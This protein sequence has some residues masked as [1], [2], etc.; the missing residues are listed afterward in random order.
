MQTIQRFDLLD[1]SQPA[2]EAFAKRFAAN[3]DGRLFAFVFKDKGQAD[4]AAKYL[5]GHDIPSERSYSFSLEAA[6]YDRVP[7]FFLGIESQQALDAAG[8]LNTEEFVER[9][10]VSDYASSQVLVSKQARAYLEVAAPT[11]GWSAVPGSSMSVMT[12]Q[13]KLAPPI[14]LP[15]AYDWIENTDHP[16]SWTIRGDGRAVLSQE[17]RGEVEAAG[18]V[19]ADLYSVKGEVRR[20][21]SVSLLVTP[22][23]MRGLLDHAFTGIMMPP[24]PLLTKAMLG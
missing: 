6:D 22:Q 23:I 10:F 15:I 21:S 14:E 18:I 7:A 19:E 17:G 8:K 5:D 13:K 16:G 12:P 20:S 2:V 1:F 11:L 24:L 9:D 4:E 3:R